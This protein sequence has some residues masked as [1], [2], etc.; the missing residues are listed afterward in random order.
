M[1]PKHHA[2][3]GG[4]RIQDGYVYLAWSL[5]KEIEKTW[6]SRKGDILEHRLIMARHLGRSLKSFEVVHHKNGNRSDNRIENL[7]LLIGSKHYKARDKIICPKCHHEFSL[8]T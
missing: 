1:G 2:W 7:K 6:F 8:S 4:R 5:L 3:K